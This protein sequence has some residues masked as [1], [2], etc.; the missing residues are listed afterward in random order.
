MLRW[1][2]NAPQIV[3]PAV[4]PKPDLPLELPDLPL[5]EQAIGCPHPPARLRHIRPERRA[6]SSETESVAQYLLRELARDK[7]PKRAEHRAFPAESERHPVDC[8]VFA[9]DRVQRKQT[10]LLQVLLHAPEDRTQAEV[11]ARNFDA[12]A[13]ARG[14]RSLV[15][16]APIGTNFAFD[17]EIEGFVLRNESTRFSGLVGQMRPLSILRSRKAADGDSTPERCGFQKMERPL[18]ESPSRSR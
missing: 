5:L 1:L 13:K 14:H 9:P 10:R 15:L 17:V 8:T 18:A 6:L 11:I 3:A 7:F 2:H 4:G 16:D 12:E